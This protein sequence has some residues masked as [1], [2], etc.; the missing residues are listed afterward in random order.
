M[1]QRTYSILFLQVLCINQRCNIVLQGVKVVQ[2][3]DQ[4][5][6]DFTKC[7]ELVVQKIS[8]EQLNVRT[9]LIPSTFDSVYS[10]SPNA[11]S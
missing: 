6:T 11:K 10:D 2:T 4:N 1:L 3:P 7:L 5:S 8:T 9:F